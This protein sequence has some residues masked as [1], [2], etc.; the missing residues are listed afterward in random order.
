THTARKLILC[1]DGT[2]D[3]FDEDNSNIIEF[4]HL[5]KK[6][7]QEQQMVYYQQIYQRL[8]WFDEAIAWN[9][10][11]HVMDKHGD[12]I[13]IFGFSRGAYTAR[14]LAGMIHK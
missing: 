1:F 3:Q 10:R 14:S 4:F 2:G 12:K 8:T 5:L 9:L 7:D 13:C 6:D 11:S